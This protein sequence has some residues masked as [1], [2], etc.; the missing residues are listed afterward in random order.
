MSA[1]KSEGNILSIVAKAD[2]WLVSIILAYSNTSFISIHN[3]VILA[4]FQ[5]L[6]GC[7]QELVNDSS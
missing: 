6:R 4:L 5:V 2:P 1:T 3:G 7:L